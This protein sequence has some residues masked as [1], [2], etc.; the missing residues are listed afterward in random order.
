MSDDIEEKTGKE[1]FDELMQVMKSTPKPPTD[2]FDK[3]LSKLI[4]LSTAYGATLTKSVGPHLSFQS[5]TS[6]NAQALIVMPSAKPEDWLVQV[7]PDV[8][9]Y[10]HFQ[11][12]SGTHTPGGAYT[13]WYVQASS[14]AVYDSIAAAY[15]AEGATQRKSFFVDSEKPYLVCKRVNEVTVDIPGYGEFQVPE[16]FGSMPNVES[17]P[18]ILDAEIVEDADNSEDEDKVTF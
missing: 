9:G 8:D 3:K 12:K 10:I 4:N 2:S 14:K 5:I 7:F 6:A 11:A 15:G 13:R 17:P 1:K 16:L 18:V